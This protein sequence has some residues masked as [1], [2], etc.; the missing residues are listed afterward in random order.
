M[1]DHRTRLQMGLQSLDLDDEDEE[2]EAWGLIRSTLSPWADTGDTHDPLHPTSSSITTGKHP[3]RHPPREGAGSAAADRI[4][5]VMG[6]IPFKGGKQQ[7]QQPFRP[8]AKAPS[9]SSNF[10]PV[11]PTH[12]TRNNQHMKNGKA[13]RGL[14]QRSPRDASPLVNAYQALMEQSEAMDASY[15]KHAEQRRLAETALRLGIAQLS[16]DRVA[17]QKRILRF[18]TLK[19]EVDIFQQ[20]LDP[21]VFEMRSQHEHQVT[22]SVYRHFARMRGIQEMGIP[23]YS[24]GDYLQEDHDKIL[25]VRTNQN[26]YRRRNA[27]HCLDTELIPRSVS[28]RKSVILV[29]TP[30]TTTETK[31]KGG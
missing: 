21:F 30:P 27:G 28:K 25:T 11:L 16:D 18:Q 5:V 2:L 10:L 6:S 20:C 22:S 19:N 7:L 15:D 31:Q 17:A 4:Q 29:A 26:F 14:L 9:S 13:D 23:I 12:S 8:P 24:L 1:L 3:P